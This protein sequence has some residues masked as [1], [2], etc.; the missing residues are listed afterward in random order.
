[1][2]SSAPASRFNA[3]PSAWSAA[4]LA[5]PAAPYRS[6]GRGSTP[7]RYSHLRVRVAD[8]AQ[9]LS[10]GG[11]GS[12]EPDCNG[13]VSGAAGVRDQGV[14]DR[15]GAV[16]AAHGSARSGAVAWQSAQREARRGVTVTVSAP[17]PRTVRVRPLPNGHSAPPAVNGIR[18]GVQQ[19][20]RET[21]RRALLH[22]RVNAHWF[23][24]TQCGITL[25]STRY[26]DT[27]VSARRA[28]ERPVPGSTDEKG[29]RWL[30]GP[31]EKTGAHW[32]VCP[33]SG[34]TLCSTRYRDTALSARR[35]DERPVPG[36]TDEKGVGSG[37]RSQ[38]PHPRS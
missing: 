15:L 24:C 32:V 14:P 33:Q 7:R 4:A 5:G 22:R 27:A 30:R 2:A 1:M 13:T 38:P 19:Y 37:G 31:A 20:Q 34:I 35:A 8:A 26:R 3:C 25:C 10:D 17:M 12:P 6:R 36:S 28:D 23:V 18:R 21:E 9:P 29:G 16:R 11:L